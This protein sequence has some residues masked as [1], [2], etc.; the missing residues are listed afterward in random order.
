M[1]VRKCGYLFILGGSTL[2][3]SLM[4]NYQLGVVK[5]LSM[6]THLTLDLMSGILLAASPLIYGLADTVYIP[7]LI[8]GILEIVASLMTKTQLEG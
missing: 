8:C 7:H 2:V 6:K 4:T 3:L 1:V 5:T